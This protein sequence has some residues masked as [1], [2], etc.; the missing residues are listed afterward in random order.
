MCF[1]LDCLDNYVTGFYQ[2]E[3]YKYVDNLEA[4]FER[5]GALGAAK[6]VRESKKYYNRFEE[7]RS[8]PD[9]CQWDESLD[10]Y[11]EEITSK[12]DDLIEKDIRK[13]VNQHFF[14]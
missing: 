3:E 1:F 13:K 9:Y 4:G 7:E 10:D 6:A 11:W 5:L 14:L 12:V 2:S 8:K